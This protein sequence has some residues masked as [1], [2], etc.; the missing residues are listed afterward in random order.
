M[1]EALF[2]GGSQ[3]R[4]CEKYWRRKNITYRQ[5][6]WLQER[7]VLPAGIGVESVF[8]SGEIKTRY[9]SSAPTVQLYGEETPGGFLARG[10]DLAEEAGCCLIPDV[11]NARDVC[12]LGSLPW[13]RPEYFP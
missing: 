11:D 13:S 10:W 7:A 1:A 5:G 12:V 8:W 9:K 2:F 6:K 4:F 3:R